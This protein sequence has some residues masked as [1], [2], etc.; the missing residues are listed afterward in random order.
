[1]DRISWTEAVFR[2]LVTGGATARMIGLWAHEKGY[3][4]REIHRDIAYQVDTR[5]GFEAYLRSLGKNTRLKLYNRRRRLGEMGAVA[6]RFWS[7]KPFLELLNE[8]HRKRWGRA[9]FNAQ[10][11]RFHERFLNH[12]ESEG[13]VPQLSVLTLDGEPV[14]ALYNIV[15]DGRVYNIQSGF[16][17]DVG[18][19]IAV[20]TLH[21]GYAL[22]RA[23]AAGDIE[24][25]DLLAGEGKNGNYKSHLATHYTPL[26]SLMVVRHALFKLVYRLVELWRHQK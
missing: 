4:V 10:S 18:K 17:E 20:G 19:G 23:F 8:F 6:E 21:L 3:L 5:I 11:V 12:I 1:M 22:E 25:F 26:V 24:W 14:S 15:F 2:D 13:G 16:L 9:C 7:P